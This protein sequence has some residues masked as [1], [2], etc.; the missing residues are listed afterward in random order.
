MA[1][2]IYQE[3]PEFILG[4]DERSSF[5]SF[6]ENYDGKVIINIEFAA[7]K[8]ELKKEDWIALRSFLDIIFLNKN[9][10]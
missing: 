10:E 9:E 1:T 6:Q 3:N 4:D 8:T 2:N 7:E 5:I